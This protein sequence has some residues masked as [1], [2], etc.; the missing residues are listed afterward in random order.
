[1]TYTEFINNI[2]STRGQHNIPED[3][4]FEKH[5]IIPRC[6]GG[7]GDRKDAAFSYRSHHENC[8]WLYPQE[9][10]IAHKLLAEENRDNVKLVYAWQMMFTKSSTT[11]RDFN[12]LAEDYAKVRLLLHNCVE[13]WNLGRKPS[14]ETRS[15]LRLARRGKQPFLGHHLS[16]S[17]KAKISAVHSGK[18]VSDKT[19]R[20][21]SKAKLGKSMP[22]EVKQKISNTLSGRESINKGKKMDE[23]FS[24]KVKLG[25]SNPIKCI[26]TGEIFLSPADAYNKTG[27]GRH[28]IKA[29]LLDS[30][31][32]AGRQKW[33][34][35]KITLEEF[36]AKVEVHNIDKN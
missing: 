29:A 31:R 2:I 1:M 7:K 22:D 6:L 28:Y 26:E 34:W 12:I 11:N 15:K 23:K 32:T 21:I 18:I 36:L 5:H 13:H 3:Q 33:H 24:L 35:V 20:K 9:H 10:F 25:K 14:E 16:D 27:I 17:A 19:R 30:S 8:I 4:Y